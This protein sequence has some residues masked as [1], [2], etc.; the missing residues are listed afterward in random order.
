M[1]VDKNKVTAEATR[2]AQKGSYDKA[3]KLYEKLL[4]EDAKDVRVLLKIGELQQKKGDNGA[5]AETFGKVADAYGEQGFFLKAVAV[6]KQMLKLA[7]EDLRVNERL[8]GLYQQLGILSDAMG[9][10][11]IVAT[12]AEHAGDAGRLLDVLKR[13][14]ELE[15]ENVGSAVKL[16]DLHAKGSQPK[17]ALEQFRR[18]AEA[19]KRNNR[20]DEYVKVAERIA[21]LAPEDLALTRELAHVYLAKG[22]TK[23]AL[24]KLQLLFKA[25]PKDLDTLT[26]LAQAFK[27]LG[28]VQKTVSVYR[29]LAHLH[30]ERGKREE[31]RATWG[32]LLELAPEDPEALA[33][34]SPQ[35]GAPTPPPAP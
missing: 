10:L 34:A 24:A 27:D 3:I 23:R 30:E 12:A 19:L 20:A 4:A 28:Q 14:V 7:P 2:L 29:E 18:A 31:A 25:D 15:P 8:A 17:L 9:Q 6:Y 13:M 33:A 11:Q 26:S 21:A 16:G 5:A 32:R 1:A 35:R 22:D